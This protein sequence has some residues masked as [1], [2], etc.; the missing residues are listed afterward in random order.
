MKPSSCNSKQSHKAADAGQPR[1]KAC[2]T[3]SFPSSSPSSA[4]ESESSNSEVE[5]D[6]QTLLSTS[7]QSRWGAPKFGMLVP[8]FTTK[9]ETWMVWFAKFEAIADDNEWL[10]SKRLSMLLPKLQG[11][12]GKYMFEVLSCKTR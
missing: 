1:K 9:Q 2:Q 4:L 11:V 12:A 7:S 3:Q 5:R 10:E 8:P 6:T